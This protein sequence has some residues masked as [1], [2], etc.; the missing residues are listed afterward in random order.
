MPAF[1]TAAPD[2]PGS[3]TNLPKA[4]LIV[5]TVSAGLST[6]LSLGCVWLQLKN[7]RKIQLQR[8]VVRIL[9]M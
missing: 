1:D 8:I 7:Y 5:A 4:V 9:L 6:V 3:G 2:I